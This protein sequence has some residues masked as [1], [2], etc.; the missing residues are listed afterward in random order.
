MLL[1]DSIVGPIGGRPFASVAGGQPVAV[2][3]QPS[4]GTESPSSR[5]FACDTS[6]LTSLLQSAAD[7]ST[8]FPKA[9]ACAVPD[10]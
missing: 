8:A 7:V 2:P 5:P 10:L 3:K 1:R 6:V 4:W 9:V